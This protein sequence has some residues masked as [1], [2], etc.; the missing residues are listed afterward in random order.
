MVIYEVNLVVKQNIAD[1]YAAW[2]PGHIR[3]M[4]ALPG[5][6][7]AEWLEDVDYDPEE[8]AD[9]RWTIHYRLGSHDDFIRYA[10]HDAERMRGEAIDRFGND[11]EATRRILRV[12]D[13][14]ERAA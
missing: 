13:V 5:F 10:E 1:D 14:F 2:L 6:E 4:L 9:P 11:F 12:E 7:A 3:E 8:G